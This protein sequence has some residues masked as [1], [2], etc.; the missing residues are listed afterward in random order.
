[1]ALRLQVLGL[2]REIL[3]YSRDAKAPQGS[4]SYLDQ[5]KAEF[6]KHAQEASEDV[7]K[8][9]IT[10]AES[11][12]GYLKVIAPRRSRSVA[13]GKQSFVYR[14]GEGFVETTAGR[15]KKT[16]FRDDRIDP[17]DLARHKRLLEYAI[18]KPSPSTLRGASHDWTFPPIPI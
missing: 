1:M 3:K 5:A 10:K 11:K 14:D 7:V 9:L 18:F 13:G 16:A 15:A 8:M 17:D 4:L 6:R 12:L 2:Y